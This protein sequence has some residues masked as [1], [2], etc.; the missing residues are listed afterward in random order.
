[1]KKKNKKNYKG[2]STITKIYITS[3]I[4]SSSYKLLYMKYS[5][6]QE[7][8]IKYIHILRTTAC[9]MSLKRVSFKND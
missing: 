2:F 8:K 6:M 3:I 4:I 5:F 7:Y 1:M 9:V